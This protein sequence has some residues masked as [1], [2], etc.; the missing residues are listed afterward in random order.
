MRKNRFILQ[1]PKGLWFSANYYRGSKI[2]VTAYHEAYP[3][4]HCRDTVVPGICVEK[5][6]FLKGYCWGLFKISEVQNWYRQVR[7][8]EKLEI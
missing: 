5:E 3:E 4:R 1:A 8:S 7:Q 2:S 6:S